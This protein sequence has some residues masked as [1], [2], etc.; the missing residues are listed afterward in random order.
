[1]DRVIEKWTPII[2]VLEQ[3]YY[4]IDVE[5]TAIYLEELHLKYSNLQRY[6]NEYYYT[7]DY[8]PIKYVHQYVQGGNS[9]FDKEELKKS[10]GV[11]MI[12]IYLSYGLKNDK[13]IYEEWCTMINKKSLDRARNTHILMDEISDKWELFIKYQIKRLRKKKLEQISLS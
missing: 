3:T 4:N 10:F 7:V 13:E 6:L 2:K 11:T 1:M 8:N 9:I 5:K 12:K